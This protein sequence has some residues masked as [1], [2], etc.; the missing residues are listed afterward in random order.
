MELYLECLTKW[1]LPHSRSMFRGQNI[2]NRPPL[3]CIR[4]V[5]WEYRLQIILF[6]PESW[7]GY[8]EKKCQY[9][10]KGIDP[11]APQPHDGSA[12]AS[13]QTWFAHETYVYAVVNFTVCGVTLIACGYL[14]A[15]IKTQRFLQHIICPPPFP[16]KEVE[17]DQRYNFPLF[18]CTSSSFSNAK[19]AWSSRVSYAKTSTSGTYADPPARP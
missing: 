13:P 4:H 14:V 3:S 15:P 6:D 1:R 12:C 19:N 8:L 2:V 11:S 17:V 9:N 10:N 5:V 18:I 16:L 7:F